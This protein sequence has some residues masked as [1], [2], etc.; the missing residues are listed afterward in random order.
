MHTRSDPAQTRY[1]TLYRLGYWCSLDAECPDRSERGIQ[2]TDRSPGHDRGGGL[3]PHLLQH[4]RR[5]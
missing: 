2:R 1:S 3:L 4:Q 5:G